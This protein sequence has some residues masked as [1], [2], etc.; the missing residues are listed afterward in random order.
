MSSEGRQLVRLLCNTDPDTHRVVRTRT[1]GSFF[2]LDAGYMYQLIVTVNDD[3]RLRARR[4]HDENSWLNDLPLS[5]MVS[6]HA[7]GVLSLIFYSFQQFCIYVGCDGSA[8]SPIGC[9]DAS[10]L[11]ATMGAR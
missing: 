11:D 9:G 1:A 5:R 4:R 2:G 10:I 3:Y 6:R 8:T 7:F